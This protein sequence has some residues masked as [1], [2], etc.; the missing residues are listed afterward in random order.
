M[1][2]LLVV[3]GNTAEQRRRHSDAGGRVAHELYT[4]VLRQ[5]RSDLSFDIAFP[6]DGDSSLPSAAALAAFDGIVWT[7]SALNIYNDGP[8]VERQ[9]AFARSCFRARVPQFGS[10]WGLQVGVVAAGGDIAL[11]AK[12]RE[13]G[14]ARKIVLTEPGRSHALYRGKPLVFDALAVHKDGI[15]KL[16]D[17]ACVLSANAMG[18]QALSITFDGGELWGVQYH[19]EYHFGEVAS[20]MRRYAPSL[21][22]EGLFSCQAE[23]DAAAEEFATLDN[24]PSKRTQWCF[25]L[26]AE[27]L[28]PSIRRRELANWIAFVTDHKS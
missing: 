8:E 20:C 15:A 26:D 19:P 7:G 22:E 13:I 1:L 27:I 4:D 17:G 23:I 6:A 25:G 12:G 2:K 11:N 10:C 16:P 21:T 3:E 14:I 28:D 18:I 24:I 9:I 5:I